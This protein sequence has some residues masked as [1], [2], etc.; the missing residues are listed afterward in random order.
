MCTLGTS[1]NDY[2]FEGEDLYAYVCWYKLGLF[3]LFRMER[4]TAL[5]QGTMAM[6]H[7]SSIT[8]VSQIC[9]Q[10]ECSLTIRISTFHVLPSLQTEIL[11]P[12]RSWGGS[13][14]YKRVQ[15]FRGTCC[16]YLQGWSW[17]LKMETACSTHISLWCH[18][19]EDYKP[20]DLCYEKLKTW[21]LLLR[22][23]NVIILFKFKYTRV[24][25]KV[26]GNNFL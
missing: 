22:D 10:Y 20:N 15:C 1:F 4:H 11:K 2:C 7:V 21:N 24:V 19:S 17:A 3:S 8:C 23:L 9:C 26:M 16:L 18:S 25:L 5:M 12:T 13:I 6:W 14:L